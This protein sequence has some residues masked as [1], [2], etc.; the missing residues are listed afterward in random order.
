MTY[1]GKLRAEIATFTVASGTTVS[2]NSYV[3]FSARTNN[4]TGSSISSDTITLPSGSYLL[5]GV[6]GGSKSA[7]ADVLRYQF[8]LDGSLVGAIGGLNT[9]YKTTVDDAKAQ[10]SITAN[11]GS[12]KFKVILESSS[13]NWTINPDYS[14]ILL[15]RSF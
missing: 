11:S 12:L 13:T 4:I 2:T 14:Y 3:N 8:E 5:R 7:V 9:S 10:F 6:I 15:I 1:K